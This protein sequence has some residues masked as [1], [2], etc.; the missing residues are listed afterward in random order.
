LGQAGT[1]SMSENYM[2]FPQASKGRFGRARP[3]HAVK[4]SVEIVMIGRA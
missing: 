1:T 4:F 2:G 3:Q